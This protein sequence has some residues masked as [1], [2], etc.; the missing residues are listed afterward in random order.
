MKLD[1]RQLIHLAAV[2]QAGSVSEAAA[3]LGISQPA[4]SKTLSALE[5]RLDAELFVKGKRPLQP[6][7]LGR[8]LAEHGQT[9]L[10]ASRRASETAQ[11]F[12]SGTKGLVRIGGTPFFMEGIV[13]GMIARFQN[14]YPDVRVHQFQGYMAE[15]RAMLEADRIDLAISPIGMLGEGS[16][17]AFEQILPGGNVV[18]CRSTHPLTIRKSVHSSDL[19]EFPWVAPQPGSPLNADLD[20]ILLSL[21][22]TSVKVLMSGSGLAGLLHYLSETDALAILPH[23]VVHAL[24]K[25]HRITALPIRIP[26]LERPLGIMRLSSRPSPPVIDAFAR[27]VAD[28]FGELNAQISGHDPHP[29]G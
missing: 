1:E 22:A 24:H 18:A 28:E 15:L 14:R 19:L 16:D 10:S 3:L 13:S 11:G 21:G 27:F 26:H 6:T 25:R 9:M 23:S 5:R 29:D 17:I 8:A 12:R 4:V 7:P 2:V 20:A